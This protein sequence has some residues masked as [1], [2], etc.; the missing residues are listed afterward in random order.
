MH[1][2]LSQANLAPLDAPSSVYRAPV[3][4]E[5]SALQNSML[6]PLLYRRLHHSN[7]QI[8]VQTNSLTRV[9]SSSWILIEGLH[10]TP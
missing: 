5:E 2:T 4:R 7:A 9:G 6:A 8:Y 10:N 1:F 3:E